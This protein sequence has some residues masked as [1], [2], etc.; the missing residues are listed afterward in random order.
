MATLIIFLLGFFIGFI[1]CSF[2]AITAFIVIKEIMFKY[3][4]PIKHYAERALDNLE[5]KTKDGTTIVFPE[6]TREIFNKEDS[7]LSDLLKN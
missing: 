5:E 3:G 6:T 4:I 2:L 7:N 1:F